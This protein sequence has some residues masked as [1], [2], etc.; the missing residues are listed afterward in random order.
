MKKYKCSVCGHEYD[1]EVGDLDGG[2]EAGTDFGNM[3]LYWVC[4]VCC[5]AKQDFEMV[6]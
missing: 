3:P 5:A 4:L 1:P 6:Q 2:I